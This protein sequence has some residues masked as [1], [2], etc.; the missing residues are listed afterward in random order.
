MVRSSA[1]KLARVAYRSLQSN[2]FA[3]TTLLGISSTPTHL[4]SA[5]RFP[6]AP[7]ACRQISNSAARNV[8][9][10]DGQNLENVEPT[11][12]TMT[13]AELTDAEYH[14]LADTYMD[15]LLIRLE[16]LQDQREDVD[17]EYSVL[18]TPVTSTSPAP[19][20]M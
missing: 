7:S 15:N 5:S 6:V 17:V 11:K 1:S 20:F 4:R 14:A 10:P 18:E 19:L 9:T 2:R 16:E 13:A 8:I 12:V 3:R